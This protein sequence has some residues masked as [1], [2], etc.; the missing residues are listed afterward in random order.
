MSADTPARPHT[1]PVRPLSR[2][3]A[4][5]LGGVGVSLA[6]LVAACGEDRGGDSDPGRVGRAEPPAELD[7]P[8][9][10][11]AVL[12]RTA[13]SLELTA[14]EVYRTATGLGVFSGFT[15]SLVDRIVADH[16][17]VAA[18]MGELTASVGGTPWTS[19]NPWLMERLVAPVIET[20]AESDDV[21][22]DVFELRDLTRERR[23][24]DPPDVGVDADRRAVSG[25]HRHRRR[26]RSAPCGVARHR[27][28]G[29]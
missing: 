14:V 20:I 9:V 5:R 18:Q 24:L 26:A 13:S 12:L 25:R 22:R 3:D 27:H 17:Q 8:P 29:P 2:R 16:E 10:N 19:P 1:A 28:A 4:L 21:A 11:D 6:A 15:A 23:L 7:Q